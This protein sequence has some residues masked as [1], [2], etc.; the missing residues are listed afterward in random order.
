MSAK[1]VAALVLAVLDRAVVI[2]GPAGC[3]MV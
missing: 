2:G 1:W 3:P